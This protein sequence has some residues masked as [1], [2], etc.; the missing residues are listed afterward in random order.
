MKNLKKYFS[1]YLNIFKMSFMSEMTHKE[2][3]LTWV[4]VHSVSLLTLI[5]FFKLVY[6]N[7]TQI[8]GWNQY[9]SL[10]VLGTG[11]LITG[12]GSLTF[13]PFMYGFSREIQKGEFDF[14]LT[15]PLNILFQSAFRWVDIEDLMV[16][17][18]AI[19]LI[20]YSV[21]K[22][23]PQNI[24][25]NTLGYVLMLTS[26]M[27]FLFSIL[28][29]IQSLAFR[30]IHINSVTDFYWSLVNITK[31]PA[32]A[33][34]NVSQVALYALVPLAIVSSVPSEV[35]MGRWEP[36][37][38]ISSLA[39]SAVSFMVSYQVFMSSLKHYSSASS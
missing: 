38:I 29:L 19:L 17:P 10:L 20:I 36:V 37:W 39:L 2:N 28:T 12:L 24:L 6:A 14:K 4:A 35:L 27:L 15:K 18:N 8:N 33:I 25:L 7:V 34:K 30:F 23:Q 21:W 9:Q 11:T 5:I 32:K 1:I 26:S 31:Y 13:F 3:F 16:T 22:L